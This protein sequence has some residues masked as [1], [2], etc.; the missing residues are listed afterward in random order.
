MCWLDI[1]CDSLG[2]LAYMG[3]PATIPTGCLAHFINIE[4]GSPTWLTL[5][6]PTEWC[7]DAAFCSIKTMGAATE[8]VSWLAK[9]NQYLNW[10][11]HGSI[12][13]NRSLEDQ[14]GN[15]F[16]SCRACA[17]FLCEVRSGWKS[18]CWDFPF[19]LFGP[20]GFPFSLCPPRSY[21]ASA[22]FIG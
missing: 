12:Q 13:L 3:T 17:R 7:S 11:I 16:V 6:A 1:V 4:D 9:H 2:C 8:A 18:E 22:G 10:A 21:P 15:C 20:G 19:S 5:H 14:A